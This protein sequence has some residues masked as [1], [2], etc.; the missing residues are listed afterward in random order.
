MK[1]SLN[2]PLFWLGLIKEFYLI[3]EILD[4][5]EMPIKCEIEYLTSSLIEA[6]ISSHADLIIE[7]NEITVRQV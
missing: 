2:M 1:N 3:I 6:T 7:Y 4:I 5:T